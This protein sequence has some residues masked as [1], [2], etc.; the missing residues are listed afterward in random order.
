MRIIGLPNFGN[1]CYFN[2]A[3]QTLIYNHD[4]Y[5]TLVTS[6]NRKNKEKDPIVFHFCQLQSL[7][8]GGIPDVTENDVIK[9]L[10]KLHEEIMSH[11]N[12][13]FKPGET[14]D[15]AEL[16]GCLL[17]HFHECCKHPVRMTLKNESSF[18]EEEVECFT[19]WKK[20][21]ETQYSDIIRDFYGQYVSALTCLSCNH[22][23]KTY[24]EY[25]VLTVPV[26]HDSPTLADGLR[27][28]ND[29]E[30]IDGVMCEKCKTKQQCTKQV[31][32]CMIPKHLCIKLFSQHHVAF[33]PSLTLGTFG[34]SHN[35]KLNS[36][37]YHIG[38]ARE[39]H[40]YAHKCV[41]DKHFLLD[42]QKVSKPTNV[43]TRSAEVLWFASI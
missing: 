40:Y 36:V 31:S 26:P 5:K 7:C 16:I 35:H 24:A 14:G 21:F 9:V 33:I 42:D 2:S 38:S 23:S 6:L 18:S 28:F 43:Q 22:V 11:K 37:I 10:K 29:T 32:L 4:L 20:T 8:I 13:Y 34:I 1:S 15:S 25:N 17:D 39:G 12:F 30:T 19:A 27:R 3:L 41:K